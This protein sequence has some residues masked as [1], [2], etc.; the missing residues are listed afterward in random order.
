[1]YFKQGEGGE[2]YFKQG[3]GGE[4]GIHKS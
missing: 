3:E 4:G 2:L 1:L